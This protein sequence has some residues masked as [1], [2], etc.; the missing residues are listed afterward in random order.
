ML[1]DLDL[2]CDLCH[3]PKDGP[4]AVN[5]VLIQCCDIHSIIRASRFCRKHGNDLFP[6]RRSAVKLDAVIIARLQ[7]F[8]T[9]VVFR[10]DL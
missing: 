3:I 8:Q 2:C 6:F 4:Q 10:I 9:L 5:T 7:R 1:D